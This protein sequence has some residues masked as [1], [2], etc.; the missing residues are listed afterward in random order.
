L[1]QLAQLGQREV[2]I[3]LLADADLDRQ[4]AR[5]Q[6]RVADALLAQHAAHVVAQLLGLFL[7]HV[8]GIDLKQDVRATL[9]I[10]PQHEMTLRPFRP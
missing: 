3:A 7:A 10:E 8:V 5:H 1:R 2:E 4:P 9:Q 6:A